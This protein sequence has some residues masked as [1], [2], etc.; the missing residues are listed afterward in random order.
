MSEA[1]F[2]FMSKNGAGDGCGGGGGGGGGGGA[3][4]VVVGL[5]GLSGKARGGEL[6]FLFIFYLFGW[7]VR[8]MRWPVGPPVAGQVGMGPRPVDRWSPP[9]LI[10]HR[11]IWDNRLSF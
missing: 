7:G 3:A 1:M 6:N 4:A 10:R 5:L 11:W 9:D 2:R 8:E